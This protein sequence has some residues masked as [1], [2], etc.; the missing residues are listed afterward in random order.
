MENPRMWRI[1]VNLWSELC[2]EFSKILYFKLNIKQN[3]YGLQIVFDFLW[4]QTWFWSK[5]CTFGKSPI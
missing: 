4:A 2:N 3:Q 5:D 1:Y